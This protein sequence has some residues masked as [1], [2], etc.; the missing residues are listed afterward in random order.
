M[1]V[2]P[3]Y[4]GAGVGRRL[5]GAALALAADAGGGRVGVLTRGD[6]RATLELALAHGFV[7]CGNAARQVELSL[8]LPGTD[9]D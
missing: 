2:H 5:V 8:E 1:F 9:T 6:N 7:V 4:H 3:D